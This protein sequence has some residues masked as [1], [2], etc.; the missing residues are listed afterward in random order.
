MTPLAEE[1]LGLLRRQAF[2]RAHAVKAGVLGTALGCTRRD[3]QAAVEELRQG[4]VFV[5][6]NRNSKSGGLY[7]PATDEERRDALGSF[8]KAT[9]TQIQTFNRL[10][11]ARRLGALVAGQTTLFPGAQRGER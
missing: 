11:R 4:G 1:L 8:R 7:L 9:L 5:A 2:G 6:S 3:V 10:K